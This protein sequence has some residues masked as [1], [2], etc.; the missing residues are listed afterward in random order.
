MRET[1]ILDPLHKFLLQ[2]ESTPNGA[3]VRTA[4]TMTTY[5]ELKDI[6]LQIAYEIKKKNPSISASDFPI[7]FLEA[8]N[9][10]FP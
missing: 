8:F 7:C 1:D 6:A 10:Q 3:A 2:A 5:Q 9:M 4:K